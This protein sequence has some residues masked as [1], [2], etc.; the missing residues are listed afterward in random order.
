MEKLDRRLEVRMSNRQKQVL[1]LAASDLGQNSA[2]YIRNFIDGKIEP[3]LA[4]LR[5]A[6]E[7][8]RLGRILEKKANELDSNSNDISEL[9]SASKN[10]SL[11]ARLI[12]S[13]HFT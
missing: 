8:V 11:M 2:E 4:L 13:E 6:G 12:I 10:L 7:L 3:D 5:E 1:E 9:M